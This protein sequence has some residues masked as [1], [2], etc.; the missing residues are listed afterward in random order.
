MTCRTPEGV[1]KGPELAD[2][3]FELLEVGDNGFD[4][5]QV[6]TRR[7]PEG[8]LKGTELADVHPELSQILK[9]R[10]KDTVLGDGRP[11]PMWV[12]RNVL[13]CHAELEQPLDR[14]DDQ[15]DA[16]LDTVNGKKA[17]RQLL[18]ADKRVQ[19]RQ[20]PGVGHAHRR[21]C[22]VDGLLDRHDASA[23]DTW[24]Q[25]NSALR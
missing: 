18:R 19:S 2:V 24:H 12:P 6:V 11:E 10:V 23:G 3:H 16:R 5:V 17:P 25:L 7:A 4:T 22:R 14:R 20:L 21:P 9:D 1:L 13:H 15:R 8:V